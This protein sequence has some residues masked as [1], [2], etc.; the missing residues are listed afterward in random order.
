MWQCLGVYAVALHL[1]HENF[2]KENLFLT[3]AISELGGRSLTQ[4]P[5]GV[6]REG[7]ITPHALDTLPDHD[8]V[9]RML[10]LKQNT[11]KQFSQP[12]H[13][14]EVPLAFSHHWAFPED[15]MALFGFQGQLEIK[16]LHAPEIKAVMWVLDHKERD[17]QKS[18]EQLQK[19]LEDRT[20]PDRARHFLDSKALRVEAS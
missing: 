8:Q 2:L 18:Q 12:G 6:Y 16:R 1:R 3:H 4:V 7:T 17:A 9:L 10:V 5:S 20:G 13:L 19:I 15:S 11:H 14:Q